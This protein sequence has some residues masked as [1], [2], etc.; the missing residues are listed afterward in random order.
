ML[1]TLAL[2][3]KR[4]DTDNWIT[5]YCLPGL[6]KSEILVPTFQRNEMP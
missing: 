2:S 5:V 6:V 3:P 4:F 1:A